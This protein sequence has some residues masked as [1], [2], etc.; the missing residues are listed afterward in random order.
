MSI[1]RKVWKTASALAA[2][3]FVLTVNFI[4]LRKISDQGSRAKPF[5]ETR[6]R[7]VIV[8]NYNGVQYLLWH[9]VT[10]SIEPHKTLTQK[11]SHME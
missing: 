9:T 3:A 11:L 1:N 10:D 2:L 5:D 8:A 6:N 7:Q 4:S